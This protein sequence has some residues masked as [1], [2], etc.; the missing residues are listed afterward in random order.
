MGGFK[1]HGPTYGPPKPTIRIR[2]KSMSRRVQ[3]T[4]SPTELP[5]EAPVTTPPMK[6]PWLKCKFVPHHSNI[7]LFLG[8]NAKMFVGTTI[9]LTQLQLKL[10]DHLR[11][12]PQ[13]LEVFVKATKSNL[14][15]EVTL[16][17]DPAGTESMQLARLWQNGKFHPF[18]NFPVNMMEVIASPACV[19]TKA[20]TAAPTPTV[21]VAHPCITTPNMTASPTAASAHPC[22]ATKAPHPAN[23]QIHIDA[24][25]VPKRPKSTVASATP[26]ELQM[27]LDTLRATLMR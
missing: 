13:D 6:D 16:F 18:Q 27:Q 21:V 4:L 24:R 1:V 7:L 10:Q 25:P 8:G 26:A 15:V 5:T 9:F 19:S 3:V 22:V 11:I 2:K 14:E 23:I 12:G 17:N 20:P